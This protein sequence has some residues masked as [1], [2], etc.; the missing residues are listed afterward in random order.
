MLMRF[1]VDT[2]FELNILVIA[3]HG[4]K[5]VLLSFLGFKERLLILAEV[6]HL[7]YLRLDLHVHIYVVFGVRGVLYRYVLVVLAAGNDEETALRIFLY[8]PNYFVFDAANF[9]LLVPPILFLQEE[10][11]LLIGKD[12]LFAIFG[13]LQ[14]EMMRDFVQE[15]K[16]DMRCTWVQIIVNNYLVM[17]S[18]LA[19][20]VAVIRHPTRCLI[21]VVFNYLRLEATVLD[22]RLIANLDNLLAVL[23][24]DVV[25][26]RLVV[27][28]IDYQELGRAVRDQ[29]L[30]LRI[31][32]HV[33]HK[34]NVVLGFVVDWA[35]DP[36]VRVAGR[37]VLKA[38]VREHPNE[39]LVVYFLN[40]VERLARLV[41]HDKYL[42]VRLAILFHEREEVPIV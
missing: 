13:D 17:I 8:A 28:Q 2:C 22:R 3:H 40:E 16:I 35:A 11:L 6:E 33:V 38:V 37:V 7:D 9:A 23:L 18:F 42:L 12:N 21:P 29:H 26:K 39:I 24:L 30:V 32:L 34:V 36:V 19:S 25:R 1:I 31:E 27:V 20:Y 5:Y 14:Y 15:I 10:L 4:H 41:V